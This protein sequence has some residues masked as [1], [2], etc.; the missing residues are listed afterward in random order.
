MT[1]MDRQGQQHVLSWSSFNVWDR[2]H[3]KLLQIHAV[4]LDITER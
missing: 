1:L 2:S 4:G 3:E